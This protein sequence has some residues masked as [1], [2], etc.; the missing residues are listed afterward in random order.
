M[1][2]R[3]GNPAF[4]TNPCKFYQKKRYCSKGSSCPFAHLDADGND[5]HN[6]ALDPS[7]MQEE[8][9]DEGEDTA[10][11]QETFEEGQSDEVGE[12]AEPCEEGEEDLG[13][14]P[15]FGIYHGMGP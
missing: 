6:Y 12:E 4:R 8:H 9:W 2:V 15:H 1:V 11:D 3:T 13:E 5:V 14:Q 10:P 7:E